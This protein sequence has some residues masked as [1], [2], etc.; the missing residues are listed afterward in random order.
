MRHLAAAPTHRTPPS[1]RG[2][3][4]PNFVN[5]SQAG[6]RPH[7]PQQGMESTPTSFENQFSPALVKLELLCALAET[8]FIV[9][10]PSTPHSHPS[11]GFLRADATGTGE[12][13]LECSN[14]LAYPTPTNSVHPDRCEFTCHN[15]LRDS[16]CTR[17]S[18]RSC[19][20]NSVLLRRFDTGGIVDKVLVLLMKGTT[21]ARSC[22]HSARSCLAGQLRP[23]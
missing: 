7:V 6:S 1:P 20:Y 9:A 23:R 14:Y 4:P 3:E 2:L 8:D 15:P 19:H 5:D 11:P 13:G 16:Y 18:M 17:S 22:V 12:A 10:K 21:H